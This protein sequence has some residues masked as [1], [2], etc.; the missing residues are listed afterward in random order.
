M[1]SEHFLIYGAGGHARVLLDGIRKQFGPGVV[2]AF[3]NDGDQPKEIDGIPVLAYVSERF[4]DIPLLLGIGKP[5]VRERLAERVSHRFGT[6]IHP[7]ASVASDAIIGEGAVVLAGA[8][9]QSGAKVGRH[10]IINA[11][12]TVDHDAT[13]EDFVTTYPG[14]YVGFDAV[15][16]HG[17]IVNPNVVIMRFAKV[18]PHTEIRAGQIIEK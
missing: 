8:V 14:V 17:A 15:V 7:L 18:A 9:V 10:V 4:P 13:V 5:D 16:G 11:N 3:F 1:D 6:F 2:H 12:A